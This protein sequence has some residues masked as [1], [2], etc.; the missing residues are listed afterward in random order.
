MSA[1]SA[2]SCSAQSIQR[3]PAS[4][5]VLLLVF[6]S[7]SA[8][9]VKA[10]VQVLDGAGFGGYSGQVIPAGRVVQLVS[11][12][13]VFSAQPQVGLVA[14]DPYSM[15]MAAAAQQAQQ[16]QQD[17][18]AST[19]SDPRA[20]AEA[21][22][23][24]L[25]ASQEQDLHTVLDAQMRGDPQ[26]QVIQQQQPAMAMQLVAEPQDSAPDQALSQLTAQDAPD[27]QSV[28]A[29]QQASAQ[30]AATLLKGIS[31]ITSTLAERYSEAASEKANT[32]ALAQKQVNTAASDLPDAVAE[33]RKAIGQVT[34]PSNILQA[35]ESVLEQQ[36]TVTVVKVERS[37]AEPN[38]RHVEVLT[39]QRQQPGAVPKHAKALAKRPEDARFESAP[40]P[41][42]A[43]E[44][45]PAPVLAPLLQPAMMPANLKV[46]HQEKKKAG[47]G[48]SF[49]RRAEAM[50]HRF[51]AGPASAVEVISAPDL[52]PSQAT[53]AALAPNDT[54]VLV[55]KQKAKKHEHA[56]APATAP[57]DGLA[58]LQVNRKYGGDSL[59]AQIAE[60]AAAPAQPREAKAAAAA[61]G[62][63][64]V[65]GE[66]AAATH[67]AVIWSSH[68]LDITPAQWP[69]YKASYISGIAQGANVDQ[70]QVSIV[71]VTS[72][73]TV[74]V[75]TQIT[76]PNDD[77]AAAKELAASLKDAQS[78]PVYIPNFG[79]V[80]VSGVAQLDAPVVP[81]FTS[82]Q[83]SWTGTSA[84][85]LG[86]AV[87]VS[88]APALQ[89]DASL[90][91]TQQS[92][93]SLAQAQT[94]AITDVVQQ[95]RRQDKVYNNNGL[96]LG[97]AIAIPIGVILVVACLLL[98]AKAQ[99][100][101][102]ERLTKSLLTDSAST[103]G[104]TAKRSVS[105]D[106][107]A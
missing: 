93:S 11:Q 62:S 104:L 3:V 91:T 34:A 60:A 10:Q 92:I 102:T 37:S 103:A 15:L 87:P 44:S 70:S 21:Q 41:V 18:E 76:Y 59:G 83:V 98:A 9:F 81:Q 85:A 23:G 30:L 64:M 69:S 99:R 50:L 95:V 33:E 48:K 53:H 42:G 82:S 17:Q 2:C 20:V 49:E 72:A 77:T 4:A 19:G 106:S 58:T 16:E 66:L 90:G 97:A 78:A 28:L 88:Y 5:S 40:A 43:V 25:L 61:G 7:I 47:A 63:V 68:L 86:P 27:A 52:A 94:P 14:A 26:I 101:R 13:Q 22:S 79:Q 24:D 1:D 80:Q 107:E 89:P 31:N 105:D 55:S 96:P 75:N 36:P 8:P 45:A 35:D 84:A 38:V 56:V 57:A 74:T 12:P 100:A 65:H 32:T 51:A 39:L 54:R 29:E 73:S 71:G 46:F 6:L 67:P